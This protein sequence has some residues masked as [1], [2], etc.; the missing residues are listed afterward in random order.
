MAA[1]NVPVR[2]M[3]V[4]AVA[5]RHRVAHFLDEDGAACFDGDTREHRSGSVFDGTRDDCLSQRDVWDNQSTHDQNQNSDDSSHQPPRCTRS[6][7]SIDEPVVNMA[8]GP[9]KPLRTRRIDRETV[10]Q[11]AQAIKETS[12]D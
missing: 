8:T 1:V 3:S 9:V 7:V 10:P 2:T 11:V 6:L 4:N 5:V 12:L